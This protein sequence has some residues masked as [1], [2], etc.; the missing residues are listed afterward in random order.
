M[1]THSFDGVLAFAEFACRGHARCISSG[2]TVS[3]IWPRKYM[4]KSV[5]SHSSQCLWCPC[6]VVCF[7]REKSRTHVEHVRVQ[8]A[9]ARMVDLFDR[10]FEFGIDVRM[11]RN[12]DGTGVYFWSIYSTIYGVELEFLTDLFGGNMRHR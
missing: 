10:T 11:R 3:P 8:C 12:D 4:I 2:N 7:V 9:L 5:W 1:N 6:I